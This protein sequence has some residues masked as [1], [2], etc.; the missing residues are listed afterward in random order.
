MTEEPPPLTQPGRRRRPVLDSSLAMLLVA[1]VLFVVIYRSLVYTHLD[2]TAAMFLGVPMVLG[3]FAAATT[4][5]G[6]VGAAMKYVTV[7]MCVLAPLLGEGSVCLLMSVPIVY[8]IAALA[9]WGAS[10]A[11]R[12]AARS[13]A[14]V[15]FALAALTKTPPSAAPVIEVTD[16]IE[17]DAPP[18]VAW[19][20]MDTLTLPLRPPPFFLRA[21]FP[22][23]VAVLGRGLSPG[24]ER[25]IVF[26][27]G[28]VVCH[29]TATEPGR[30]A[31][32]TVSYENVGHEFFDRWLE[33]EDSAFT[34]EP[35]QGGRTRITH[36]T[37]YRRLLSPGFY[38]G[39]LEEYGVHTM[40]RYLLTAF[41]DSVAK[42]T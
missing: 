35:I 26:H 20:A 24:S 31:K 40:Q 15:P 30:S 36:T 33:L 16:A 8:P 39:P 9:A 13:V 6:A 11:S 2:R 10:R 7:S 1:E 18:G 25:R 34:F 22:E 5:Q 38:F 23:P 12:N 28:T 27:N 41:A 19:A 4:P 32:M 37:H 17:V 42:T 3:V 29:L 14:L 21:G